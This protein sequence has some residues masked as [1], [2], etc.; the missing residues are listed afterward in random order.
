ML[1]DKVKTLEA[2]LQSCMIAK[3]EKS[4][5]IFQYKKPGS[6]DVFEH[7]HFAFEV[8]GEGLVVT[9]QEGRQIT[10]TS[11]TYDV[12]LAFSLL[13]QFANKVTQE[14]YPC[15]ETYSYLLNTT[16]ELKDPFIEQSGQEDFE[17]SSEEVAERLNEKLKGLGSK[18]TIT[19][20]Y[21][22]E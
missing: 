15:I 18:K 4:K 16:F 11:E 17:L 19:S 10:L 22:K 8:N 5:V 13:D 3:I 2:L 1:L 7:D 14:E 12:A 21:P 9:E 20:K 6:D